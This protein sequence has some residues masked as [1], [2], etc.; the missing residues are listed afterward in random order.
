MLS[1][2]GPLAREA[3][4]CSQKVAL[5]ELVIRTAYYLTG[6]PVQRGIPGSA[7]IIVAAHFACKDAIARRAGSK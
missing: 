7:A 2:D 1:R 3:D 6:G 4:V 5:N